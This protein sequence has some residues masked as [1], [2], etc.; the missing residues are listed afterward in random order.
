MSEPFTTSPDSP[1]SVSWADPHRH[2]AFSRWLD[3]IAPRHGL[4]PG[5]VRPASADASF[6]RYLRV[7]SMAPTLGT[8][9]SSLPPEGASVALGRP[10][11]DWGGY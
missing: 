5:T 1:V 6:R 11:G 3:G 2:E 9:V 8:H 7:D 4:M 10:G